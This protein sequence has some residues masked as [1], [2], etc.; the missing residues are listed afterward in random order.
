MSEELSAGRDG[1]ERRSGVDRR[2]GMARRMEGRR[3][4][5]KTAIRL[6]L[7]RR[8]GKDRRS[9]L[10]RRGAASSESLGSGLD[11]SG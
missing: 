10:E 3:I 7:N 5:N 9:E 1:Q 8:S 2:S 11:E 4:W 6:F